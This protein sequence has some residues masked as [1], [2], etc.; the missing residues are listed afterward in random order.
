MTNL[1]TKTNCV[2]LTPEVLQ[3]ELCRPDPRGPLGQ[4]QR[5][6]KR[7]REAAPCHPGLAENGVR[8]LN[9]PS[10][11]TLLAPTCSLVLVGCF[12][13]RTPEPDRGSP[14]P[15]ATTDDTTES[16]S[17][18]VTTTET[19][20]G[21]GPYRLELDL[22]LN[23]VWSE[24]ENAILDAQSNTVDIP[25]SELDLDFSWLPDQDAGTQ[26]QPVYWCRQ[27]Y[28][29]PPLPNVDPAGMALL[30][31]LAELDVEDACVGLPPEVIASDAFVAA[32]R[33]EYLVEVHDH[34][35]EAAQP[36]WIFDYDDGEY[37]GVTVTSNDSA[38]A[39]CQS[40]QHV[41]DDYGYIYYHWPSCCRINQR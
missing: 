41:F 23:Y 38:L 25:I 4:P 15:P 6:T 2:D 29:L 34:I 26:V 10:L 28:R 13:A 12:A 39:G 24:A 17:P 40:G 11:A 16:P 5:A 9:R 31:D 7:N 19:A 8:M 18:E 36:C 35:D 32:T 21:V 33:A 1:T 14:T 22:E 30:I 3:D 37:W 20:S 27:V